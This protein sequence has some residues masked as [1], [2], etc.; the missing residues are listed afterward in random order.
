AAA[1]ALH[2]EGVGAVDRLDAGGPGL[3][4]VGGRLGPLEVGDVVAGPLPLLLVPPHVGLALA[5]RPALGV[6]RGTAVEDATVGRPHPA[7]LQ[8]HPVLVAAGLA[9]GGLVDAVG[10]DT[11]VDPAAAHGGAVAAQLGEARQRAAGGDLVAVDLLE[12]GLGA[13]LVV[14]AVHGVVPGEV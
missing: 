10:E 7:P 2:D 5:P 13:G 11:R 1:V 3:V 8:G 4:A 14:L 6:G 9:P 12:D